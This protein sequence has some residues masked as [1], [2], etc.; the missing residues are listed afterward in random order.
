MSATATEEEQSASRMSQHPN[1]DDNVL[2]E[3]P[4]GSSVFSVSPLG[5]SEWVLTFRIDCRLE[6]G[7]V[8]FLRPYSFYSTGVPDLCRLGLQQSILKLSCNIFSD[9]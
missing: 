7:E 5:A 2:A 3:F 1:L 8:S 6:N 9:L 4:E